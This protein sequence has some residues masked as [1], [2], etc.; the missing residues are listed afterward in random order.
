M[1]VNERLLN[2][3]EYLLGC[4]HRASLLFFSSALVLALRGLYHH[5][6]ILSYRLQIISPCHATGEERDLK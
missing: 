4:R 1:T 5:C 3:L 2:G 6:Q